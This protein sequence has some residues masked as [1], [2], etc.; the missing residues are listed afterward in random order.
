MKYIDNIDLKFED[1]DNCSLSIYRA[2]DGTKNKTPVCENMDDY[3]GY[4]YPMLTRKYNQYFMDKM[5]TALG[6]EYEIV[7]KLIMK[8]VKEK[9]DNY[10]I[11]RFKGKVGE[12]NYMIYDSVAS[13]E[14]VAA[15]I[16][17]YLAQQ[18]YVVDKMIEFVDKTGK[19]IKYS[20]KGLEK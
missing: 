16:A 8:D 6:K 10:I 20:P 9:A 17:D 14:E 3:M 4:Y 19:T 2:I 1:L 11:V 18:K 5:K 13:N 12:D 7:R 15:E